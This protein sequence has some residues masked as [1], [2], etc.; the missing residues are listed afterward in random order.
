VRFVALVGTALLSLMVGVANYLSRLFYDTT[1]G[2]GVGA[3]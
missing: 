3:T 1:H 2:G